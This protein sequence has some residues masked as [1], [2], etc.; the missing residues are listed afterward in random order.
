MSTEE[1]VDSSELLLLSSPLHSVKNASSLSLRCLSPAA[2]S[3]EETFDFDFI[4]SRQVALFLLLGIILAGV[5]LGY[6]IVRRF[7]ISKEDGSV[8]AGVAQF[9]K[10]AMRVIGTTFI[11]Q[12]T[13]DTP[14][15]IGVLVSCGAVCKL[16]SSIESLHGW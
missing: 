9:V 1:Y 13:I 5:A 14:L 2:T 7:V 11:L 10:W 15:A 3:G 4:I 12:S 6:R 16:F 8:D